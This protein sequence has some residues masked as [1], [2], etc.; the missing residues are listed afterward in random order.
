MNRFTPARRLASAET[1]S[2]L[3]I[4]GAVAFAALVCALAAVA[5]LAP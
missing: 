4:V 5:A 2:D 3:A 1:A